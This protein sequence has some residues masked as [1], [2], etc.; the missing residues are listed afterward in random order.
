[1]GCGGR[2]EGM[3]AGRGIG[4]GGFGRGGGR[5]GRDGSTAAKLGLLLWEIIGRS[6]GCS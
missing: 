2:G 5:S 3:L 6:S 1:M 4:L